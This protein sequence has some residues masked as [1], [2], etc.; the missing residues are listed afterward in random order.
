MQLTLGERGSGQ[1]LAL[2]LV[3][4]GAILLVV[5]LI[6]SLQSIGRK[7]L[8]VDGDGDTKGFPLRCF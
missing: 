2:L 1:R 8:L 4:W 5:S 7:I 3:G 6:E